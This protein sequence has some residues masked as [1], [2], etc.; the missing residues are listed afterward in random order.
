MV[1]DYLEPKESESGIKES[2]P[3]Q[4]SCGQEILKSLINGGHKGVF[5][6][7]PCK[8]GKAD[9]KTS[10]AEICTHYRVDEKFLFSK[11][12]LIGSYFDRNMSEQLERH[13]KNGISVITTH[14][15]SDTLTANLSKIEEHLQG[16]EHQIPLIMVDEADYGTAK[17]QKLESLLEGIFNKWPETRVVLF[18]ATVQEAINMLHKDNQ[19]TWD[20]ISFKPNKNF[21]QM[22]DYVDAGYVKDV[23]N[24]WENNNKG[25]LSSQGRE[26]LGLLNHERPTGIIRLRTNLTSEQ[27]KELLEEYNVEAINIDSNSNIPK[28]FWQKPDYEFLYSHSNL[29]ENEE[30]PKFRMYIIK[31]MLARSVELKWIKHV[32]FYHDPSTRTRDLTTSI[33]RVGRYNTYKT[34]GTRLYI[35]RP[36]TDYLI[37]QESLADLSGKVLLSQMKAIIE[38]YSKENNNRISNRT[39]MIR[40]SEF[41]LQIL[42]FDDYDNLRVAYED[43]EVKEFKGKLLCNMN[44]NELNRYT[45]HNH[46]A[47]WKIQNWKNFS[48]VISDITKLL[49]GGGKYSVDEHIGSL[50]D[51]PTNEEWDELAN[52][53]ASLKGVK[54]Y[55]EEVEEFL[56]GYKTKFP[57]YNGKTLLI[58]QKSETKTATLT[59]NKETIYNDRF[60]N[61]VNTN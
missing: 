19:N 47:S 24:F 38:K 23:E 43:M 44:E 37:N 61:P 11:P 26:A 33:Q 49:E 35:A 6:Y 10:L 18:T 28:D 46:V 9:I 32:A 45:N 13:K 29:D 22:S 2:R 40:N 27:E 51:W 15:S 1:I 58:R 5:V 14:K 60:A 36:L 17:D 16:M 34:I 59:E 4:Y 52:T 57:D 12:V 50:I 31:N 25:K 41:N 39:K 8:S 7:A 53:A 21:K 20:I 3:E 30:P 55:A 56:R 48:S 54:Q 42:E